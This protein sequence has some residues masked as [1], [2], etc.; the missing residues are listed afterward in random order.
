MAK[1]AAV[2]LCCLFALPVVPSSQGAERVKTMLQLELQ[3]EPLEGLPLAWS[4]RNVILLD[5]AGKLWEFD[6]KEVS[7]F[8][9]T[10]RSFESHSLSAMQSRLRAEFGN[11]F[12]VASTG[13]YLVVHPR[14]HGA[15]WSRR[16]EELYRSFVHYFAVRGFEVDEPQFPLVAVVLS[17]RQEFQQYCRRQGQ[18]AGHSLLGYY[19]PADNRV[20]LYDVGGGR[21]DGQSWAA[22]SETIIHEA[23]H[24]TA[25]N[26][27]IHSRY[28]APPRWVAEGLAMMFEAPGVWNSRSFT[29]Q[30]D[31]LHGAQLAEF[32]RQLARRPEARF[33]ELVS[34]DRLFD[35]D[36]NAAYAESWAFSFYLMET[37]PRQ[38]AKYLKAT[39]RHPDFIAT[40]SAERLKD[41]TDVFG[42]N[43]RL[44]DAQLLR[45][46][47]TLK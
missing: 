15:H 46:I 19:S 24:Q 36:I 40:N 45:F 39:A 4:S 18:R 13:H 35:R 38:Y 27:G 22:N 32:R 7:K 1:I 23:T 41:F 30:S 33:T 47:S 29:R 9:A 17:D 14:G 3:G 20:A 25:F 42:E 31:R 12:E 6:P 5:R 21:D 16:F 44:I 34:S 37:Q 10:T 43:F 11:Q 28:S 2:F 26:T 8:Q